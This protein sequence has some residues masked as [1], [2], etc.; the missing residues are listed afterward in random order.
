MAGFTAD[1][2]VN[3]A[4]K[5]VFGIQGLSSVNGSSGLDWYEEQ[6]SWQPFLLNKEMYVDDVPRANSTAEADANAVANPNLIEKDDYKLSL[7]PLT[8]GRAWAAFKTFNDPNSGFN[9]DWLLPQIFGRGYTARLFQDDGSGTGPG[10]EITTTMG[11]WVP[12]Y[13]LGFIVLSADTAAAGGW[14]TPLWIR[15]YRYVGSKGLDGSNIGSSLDDAYNTGAT[16]T[17]DEGPV[18]LNSSSGYAPIQLTPSVSAP[19]QNLSAGQLSVVGNETYIYNGSINKWLSLNQETPSFGGRFAC[20]N[21]L[22]TGLHSAI[23]SGFT[24]LKNGTILGISASVGAG[25]MTKQFHVRKNGNLS[26]IT[27]FSLVGGKYFDNSLNIDFDQ[28]D[29]IQIYAEPGSLSWSPRINV[30]IAWRL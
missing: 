18:T 5:Q 16:I 2:K 11:D 15:A 20:G 22:T 21:Y 19:T 17:V 12:S 1:E 28:S 14:N 29:T 27:S 23:N 26:N 24:A 4:L 25:D 30:Q 13:K 10:S 7:V 8:N 6:Y 3:I 9:G